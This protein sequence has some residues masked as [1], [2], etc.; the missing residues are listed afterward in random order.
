MHENTII[1]TAGGI[2]K[3]MGGTI[4]KQFLVVG[5]TPI[6]I[7][8][9]FRFYTFDN[10]AQILVTLPEAWKSYWEKLCKQYHFTIPHTLLSGGKERYHSIQGALKFAKGKFVAVH[11]GLG[12]PN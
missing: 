3:R 12:R 6:L 7:Q 10:Q 2:G 1:I 4:P 5:D 11:D 8:T 9:I